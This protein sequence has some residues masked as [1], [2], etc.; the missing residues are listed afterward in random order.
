MNGCYKAAF[1]HRTCLYQ[2]SFVTSAGLNIGVEPKVF[3]LGADTTLLTKAKTT[4]YKRASKV[5][6]NKIPTYTNKY[7]S[8]SA[9]I[10][11]LH[12]QVCEL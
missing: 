3:I 6:L 7:F 1:L 8:T 4:S 12:L 10:L 11:D 5:V 9:A 2:T